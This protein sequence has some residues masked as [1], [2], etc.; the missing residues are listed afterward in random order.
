MALI[1][2]PPL[3]AQPSRRVLGLRPIAEQQVA[4]ALIT[5]VTAILVIGPLLVLVRTSLLPSRMLPWDTLAVTGANFATAYLGPAT[6]RLLVNTTVYALGS[7]LIALLVASVLT[8]LAERTDLPLRTTLRTLMFATM[9]V[10]PLALSFGWIMLLNPNNGTLNTLLKTVLPLERA[11]FDVY[12]LEMMIFISAT[13]LVPTMFVMLSGV[14]RN[15][16]P[17]LEGAGT[18]LGA[19]YLRVLRQVTLPLLSPGI[20]SVGVYMLMIMVQAFET[21]LAIGLTAQVS[22]LSTRIYMLSTPEARAPEYGTAAAFGIGLLAVAAVLMWGY[23]RATRVSER[24]RVVTGK[25]FRPRR[26]RLG[27]WRYPALGFV[28]GYFALMLAPIAALFWTS[29]LPFSR[30]PS[31]EALGSLS[32]DNYWSIVQKGLVQRAIGNT[33]ILVFGSATLTMVLSSL[34]SWLAL[35]SKARAARWLDVLAF[36]PLA[37][38]GI[39]MALAILMMYIRTP[40]YG[41]IWIIVLAHVTAH[42]A[43]GTRTMNGA[44]IQIHP[45]LENAA[46]ASGASWGT[47]LRR[48]LLPMLWPQFLNGWLWV[49]AHSLRDL[50]MP[51]MLMSTG[52]LVLSSAL[53]LLWSGGDVTTAAALVI[54]MMLGLLVL[55]LPLQIHAS[56]ISTRTSA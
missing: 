37:I 9:T 47:S 8:W 26:V 34:I 23:F 56:A 49:V 14:F 35:R 4:L 53:W 48:I 40:L 15:M 39:V 29:L 19:N 55:V 16:D 51:L 44:L 12:S 21:P 38:P 27:R 3:E 50:T 10:P 30:P 22:V 33:F 25:A 45:E 2:N 1:T 17:Q 5:V 36:A 13:A 41:T 24:F 52:N 46:M 43:F 42:L 7:V 31:L 20:L 54:L 11:V 28:A 32:L 18:V 6:M